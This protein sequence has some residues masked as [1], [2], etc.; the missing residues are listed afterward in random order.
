MDPA[1]RW[2]DRFSNIL[3]KG[4]DVVI[5]PLL[6]LRDLR[7]GE[8][9]SLPNFRCVP[10]RNLAKLS[11][12]FAGEHFNL[13]PNFKLA[14]VRPDPAHLWPGV[15]IDHFRKIKASAEREKRFVYKKIAPDK[16]AERFQNSTVDLSRSTN[17][18]THE[19]PVVLQTHLTGCKKVRHC[20]HRLFGTLRARTNCE[21][22]IAERESAARSQ[23][24]LVLFHV[25]PVFV[26]SNFNAIIRCEYLVHV[27]MRSYSVLMH[28]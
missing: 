5:C 8:P 17:A 21:D 1:R 11:H 7:N 10:L 13:K 18:G 22:K 27:R 28:I 9:R 19:T 20:C 6:D 26:K 24:L 4:D 16:L 3:E 12:C 14:F 2:S 15:T 25:T 23:N